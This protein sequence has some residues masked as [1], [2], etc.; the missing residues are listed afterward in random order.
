MTGTITFAKLLF[1]LFFFQDVINVALAKLGLVDAIGLFSSLKEVIVVLLLV[2]H[3][4]RA[5]PGRQL[6]FTSVSLMLFLALLFTLGV[7][8]GLERF[9]LDGVVFELRTLALPI[10]IFFWGHAFIEVGTDRERALEE[11]VRF[12]TG[13]CVVFAASALIDYLFLGDN[14]WTWVDVGTISRAKGYVATSS[15]AL[16]DNMYSFFFGRRAFGLAFNPLNLAYMLIPALLFAFYRHQ[17]TRFAVMLTAFI[18]SFSRLP[19][20]A[21]MASVM[22]AVLPRGLRLIAFVFGGIGVGWLV[23]A[24]REALFADPS[25]RGHFADV[26][27]ALVQQLINPLGEGVGAAG[28]YAGN[29]S[30]L[31]VESAV[32]NTANQITILGLAAYLLILAPGLSRSGPLH[33]ELRLVAAIYGITAVFAPQVFVIKSTFAFFFFLGANAALSYRSTAFFGR[34]AGV[35]PRQPVGLGSE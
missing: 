8:R 30:V 35:G 24:G 31:S 5:A 26:A 28:V 23:Y 12:Y 20:L 3:W 17:I 32:L 2:Q 25:A 6:H 1:L 29:Y 27:F 22:I 18:L 16:P 13:V 34:S 14:F 21:T 7:W 15:G 4:L 10:L 11:M 19:I 33:R 9:P